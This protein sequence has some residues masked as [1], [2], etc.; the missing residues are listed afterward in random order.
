MQFGILSPDEI[1]RMSVTDDGGIKYPETTEG[2]RPKLGGLMDP[3]QGVVDRTSR[4]LTCA[5]NMAECPGHFGHIELSKPVFHVPFITKI[6]KILRCVCYYCSRL[7]VDPNHPKVKEILIKTKGQLRRRQGY[8]YDLCKV[9]NVCDGG[10][11]DKKDDDADPDKENRKVMGCGRNQ[12]KIRRIGLELTAEWKHVNDDNQEKKIA[13]TAE[14]VLEIFKA[15]SDETCI[16]LGMDH[17]FARPDWMVATILPVPPL[18][19]RPAVVMF[20]SARNQDD[21]THKLADIIKINNQLKR[22]EQNGA[23]AHI[24]AEDTKMLQFHVATMVDNEMPGLPRAT[25]KSG[26]PLKSIKQRLK[27]KEGRIRGNLMGK[28][29]DFSGRTV[30]TPDP[31][32]RID[33]VGVPRSIAQNLTYPEIVTPFNIDRM[34]ELVNR[35]ANQYP[36]AKYILR[37][38]GDRIDLR[39]HPKSS[40]L[41]LQYG[42]KVE[43]H[44]QD[45]DYIIFNR[46][47]TLHKMSMMCHKVKIL[48]WST[49]RLNLSVT[50]PYNA[51]FDGDEMNLHLAQSL[52]TRAEISQ[53][54]SVSRM[55][56]TPQANRPVMGIVQDSLTAVNKMTRR[57]TFIC[58]EDM[59]NILMYLPRWDG[60]MPQP[61]IVR[62]KALWTGKQLFSLIIPGRINVIRTHS[63]HPDD[64]DRGSYQWI[65]PGD[66][67]VLVEDGKL[68]SGILCKK[69]LGASG[70]SLQHII[71]HELG[72]EA[73]AE[74][75]SNIQMVTN[76]WLLIEGHTIGIAD[77]IADSKTYSDIQSAIKKAKTDVVEVIEKAHNDELE[78]TPGNTLRQ[79]FENQVNRILNDAR[80]KTGSLA[81]KS[82]SEFNNFKSMVVA[83]SKGN[84]INISQVIACVG[85][86]NVEGK[87]IPFGFR[88]RTLPHFIKDD[89]GPESRGFV[90]NSYLAGLTPTEFFFHAMGGR[91]GL[92]DTAVKTA[93]TGYIQR[94]LIK[95]MES[96]MVKYDGTIRNQI[97]QLIQLRYGEDGLAGEWVEF[98][99]LP[100][101]KPSDK[102]FERGFKFDPTNEK[103]L[104]HYL[105]EDVLKKLSGDANVIAEVE[106]EYEQLL[107]DRIAVRQIFPS[108]DSKIVLPCNLQRLIWNAQ[109]IFRIHSRK[110]SNLHPVKIIQDVR[111]LS[112]KFMIVK[113]EDRLSKAA[114]TNATLLMNILVRSTL[115]SKKV[116]EEFHLSSE[117][118][119]W[120]IGE[121]ETKFIQAQVQPGEMVGALAAQS[122]GEPATQMTLNTFHYAGVSAKNVTLGVPRLKEIINVSKKP[123]TP[124]LTVFLTGQPARDAEKAKDVLCQLEHTTLRKV[125]ANTAI[126]Y[127]PD[128][129]HT[130]IDEDQEWVSIYY[131]MPDIDISR[132]S[133][134]LLRI[135]LDR[136]RMTDKKL[137]M[138]QISEKITSGFGDDLNCIFNDD[139]AE[140]LVLRIRLMNNQD[141][142]QGDMEEQ[143]DKM[144]DDTFLKHIESNMLTDMTLQGIT[145]ISKVYMQQP[146]TDD[147]KRIIIDE[148]G[149][150]KALQDWILE[151]DGT[152]LR[153]VLSV[154]NVDP[155]RT[156]TNDIVEVFEVLGIEAV[157]KAI[158]R[159]MNNVISFDG[160][161]VNYRHLALLCDVMTAKGHLMAITRH[162]INRQETGALARCSF[163]ETVDIL[164]EAAAHAEMDPMKGV[165]EAIMLGQLARIGTGCFDMMLDADKCKYGLEIPTNVSANA[166]AG[167]DIFGLTSMTP[168][169]A[170]LLG[171]PQMT[172]W[173]Q[174]S[175]AT[176]SYNSYS[177]VSGMTPGTCAGFSPIDRGYSPLHSPGWSPVPGSPGSPALTSPYIPSPTGPLSP[178]YSPDSPSYMPTSPA[179]MQAQS[180]GGY[181]SRSPVYSSGSHGYSP[182][183]PSYSPTS[184]S[185]SPTSPSYSP[186]SPSYSPTSPSYSPTSPSRSPASPSY[187]PTS[188]SYSPTSPSYS[189]TSPS[190][191]PTSPSYSPTSPSY[192]P[193]SPSYSPTSPSYSP[194]SPSYSPTSP[195]YSPTSPSYSP[196]SPSYSPTSPCYLPTSPSFSPT[197][198]NYS[199]TSPSYVPTSPSYSPTSPAFP[200]SSPNYSPSSPNY[201]HTSPQYS[202]GSPNYSPSSPASPNYSPTSPSYSPSSPNYS[203]KSPGFSTAYSPSSPQYSPT[204]PAYCPTSPRYS[205]TSP[206]YTP[207]SPAFPSSSPNYAPSSPTYSPTS[208]MFGGGD[209]RSPMTP[210]SPA[211]DS[212]DDEEMKDPANDNDVEDDDDDEDMVEA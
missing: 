159:E 137:T 80:D 152:A 100:S 50:T 148:K 177:P 54:A 36:G 89:Y 19:V 94:R 71:Y 154:E 30:I 189:P 11:V 170:T 185:Y 49:F 104:K 35:G 188:P 108:G 63:T 69:S 107:E 78:P 60:K 127:D 98:Q 55:I 86:Q 171:S 13:L 130:V 134:W 72:Y 17:R 87:R 164:V 209:D 199:P 110:P 142:K 65:S 196:T 120:L 85:Q 174:Q 102:G 157:R 191:S 116:I 184:P 123:R 117:A 161:Y 48:P 66:T 70:G 45:N 195:S 14:R 175:G 169:G 62:P 52:E 178:T 58:K 83:G 138:E 109:K 111:E 67:K 211:L 82:L 153:K 115:C 140:K 158:E 207:S 124:S 176:P 29:V 122:L 146:T 197:S 105:N 3:R 173:G 20:G 139:N 77:T 88:H 97:E 95:A 91:E 46:Q 33:Q 1:L 165:S 32:L 59:M 114:N 27:G 25:Q 24:L 149:E 42:Y 28:R 133:P 168:G 79:T 9:K 128:P 22:N 6:I 151:T 119:E 143:I 56:I 145:T 76:Q 93:E 194:T 37:E 206:G 118:F 113:G 81:Q 144:P 96:V 208:P 103:H 156:V 73:T 121:I 162:G 75:Y 155:V 39:Y 43:R 125:T 8:V 126:Y 160:S 57:D 92:I 163:E 200:P 204:S 201:S 38:N 187:S 2:G 193:T 179:L 99:N 202:P 10:E 26:R 129:M 167:R 16:I 44:M 183:S 135:E 68:L 198:P 150:F 205:P 31:M 101:L 40:D 41:H 5:G 53:L 90:E 18:P 181:S 12:P 186:T 106:K 4:C 136:K 132:L 64:E 172:P 141:S 51:D 210:G 74:F 180:P 21:L 23:A 34:T 190:Y 15:I 131:D 166:L 84:K 147:K 182:T 203:V 47:P 212:D 112:K 7:L 192:S 61:A